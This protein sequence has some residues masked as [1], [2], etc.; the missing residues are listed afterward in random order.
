M[1]LQRLIFC[2]VLPFLVFVG[3]AE[4]KDP[5]ISTDCG[6]ECFPC[7]GPEDIFCR[8]PAP[9]W[10]VEAPSACMFCDAR[11]GQ[12]VTCAGVTS[13]SQ[14][15]RTVCGIVTNGTTVVSCTTSGS[16]CSAVTVTP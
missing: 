11:P 8:E 12:Q 5:T 13:P 9:P 14:T 16:F 6:V 3:G 2:A 4:A 10:P 1:T 7:M 15:G